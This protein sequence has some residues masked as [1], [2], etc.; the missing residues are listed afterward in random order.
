MDDY[1]ST[2]GS[3]AIKPLF[4][5]FMYNLSPKTKALVNVDGVD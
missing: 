2:L 5:A 4:R 1:N 3:K